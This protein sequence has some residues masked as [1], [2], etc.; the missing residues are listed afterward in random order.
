MN[1]ITA[2]FT[3]NLILVAMLGWIIA[4]IIADIAALIWRHWER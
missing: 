1:E 3:A 2:D 4:A